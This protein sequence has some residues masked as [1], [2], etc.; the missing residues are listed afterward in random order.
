M[1]SIPV[2][3]TKRISLTGGNIDNDHIPVTPLR[4]LL[5][6]DCF[7]AANKKNGVG[8]PVVMHLEGL[9]RTIE[10][11]VGRDAKTR[12]PRSHFRERR[13]IRKFFQ[14]YGAKAGD[15]LEVESL[16]ERE[17]RLRII[18]C[19]GVHSVENRPRLRVAEF[20]AGIGLVRLALEKHGFETVFANDFDPD[21]FAIY[22]DNF[23]EEEFHPGD[24]H[25]LKPS[26]IPDCELATASFPCTDL[27]IA[28]EM[29]GIHSGESSAFWGLVDLLKEM[30]N[31]RPRMVLLENVPGFLMSR[32][33]KDFEA[34][35]LFN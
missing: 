6:S 26:D 13:W 4:D 14:H 33:G 34:A 24:I 28:G 5:P 10:T 31:R 1:I 8:R 3:R 32:N 18:N 25:L 17:Y 9:N 22:K 20:F 30:G 12:R 2:N 27:S 23:P 7:G 15:V 29:N 21:K 16:G 19:S 11:D 35:T